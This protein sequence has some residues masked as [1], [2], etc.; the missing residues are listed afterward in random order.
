MAEGVDPNTEYCLSLIRGK[1]EPRSGGVLSGK[2]REEGETKIPVCDDPKEFLDLLRGCSRYEEILNLRYKEVEARSKEGEEM[3]TKE[4]VQKIFEEQELF[5]QLFWNFYQNVLHL[6]YKP[7]NYTPEFREKFEKYK[8][9]V[10]VS[11]YAAQ[12]GDADE[13][14]EKDLARSRCHDEAARQLVKDGLVET[15]FLGRILVRAFLVDEGKDYIDS[16][17]QAD[18]IRRMRALDTEESRKR[19]LQSVE[20]EIKKYQISFD[21]QEVSEIRD[22]FLRKHPHAFWVAAGI[23]NQVPE[24]SPPTTDQENYRGTK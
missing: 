16:A 20:D 10:A 19:Y 17:R 22:K 15:E 9:S 14:K 11:L 5:K 24:V 21:S 7:E 4:E 13:I 8:E 12:K 3:P 18:R 1:I 2:E 23:Y 6:S